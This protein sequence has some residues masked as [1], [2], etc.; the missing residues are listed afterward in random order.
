MEA[1]KQTREVLKSKCV[2]RVRS[3]KKLFCEQAQGCF[4][5][6]CNEEVDISQKQEKIKTNEL[7]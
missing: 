3:D 6:P 2:L 7:V 4:L 5:H 1:N